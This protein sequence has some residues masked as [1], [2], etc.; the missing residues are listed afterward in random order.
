MADEQIIYLSPEEELTNVRERLEKI[1]SKR[2][3]LVIPAQ[4]QLRSHV[5]WR[6]LHARARELNKEILII[7]SDRQIRSV[8][9]AAGF[10]VADSLESQ[11]S[12]RSRVPSR[13]GRTSLG[14]RTSAR[15]RTPPG[16]AASSP[17]T[18]GLR[19]RQDEQSVPP[20]PP[21]QPIQPFANQPAIEPQIEDLKPRKDDAS[22]ERMSSPASSTFEIE[23]VQD[24]EY[25]PN[26]DYGVSAP[27]PSVRP[28]SPMTPLYEE[29]EPNLWEEDIQRARRI[30]EAAQGDVQGDADTM[31]P[32]IQ[33]EVAP[34][35]KPQIQDLP[36]TPAPRQASDPFS[37]IANEPVAHLPEQHAAL[38]MDEVDEGVADI[39][40]YPTDVINIED[41]GDMGD[42]VRG[43]EPSLHPWTDEVDGDEQDIPGPSRIHGM[44]PRAS[45]SGRMVPE[46]VQ[47]EEMRLPPVYDQPTRTLPQRPSGNLSPAAS[48]GP[49]RSAGKREPQ[50]VA[51]PARMQAKAKPKTTTPLRK[52]K[53]DT[54]VAAIA[55]G[56]GAIA[57]G[58]GR[59]S[60][61]DTMTQGRSKAKGKNKSRAG[62]WIGP[63]LVVLVVLILVLLA[64]FVPSAD[65]TV[66]LLSHK[67]SLP[68]KLTATSTSR[69]DVLHQTLPAQ[70]LT[71][72]NSV[73][74]S[75]RATGS[76]LVG[77][78]LAT[79]NVVF[80]Y[81]GLGQVVIPTGT[82]VA[83]KSGI[84][85]VTQAEVLADGPPTPVQATT[86]GTQGNVLATSI[87]LIP[88]DSLTK[89]QQ[90]NPGVTVNANNLTVTNPN[91]TSGGGAGKAIT[92][93]TNDVDKVRSSLAIQLQ[94]QAKN[95][96]SKNVHTG[97]EAGQPIMVETLVAT[98]AVGNVATD[99]TFTETLKLHM[100]VLIVRF[101]DLQA[102]SSAQLEASLNKQKSNQAL[103][104]Q[105]PV[106]LQQLKNLAPHNGQSVIVSFTA[107]GQVAPRISEDTIRNQVIGKSIENANQ[108]LS[109]NGSVLGMENPQ[110]SV[111]PGFFHWMPFLSQRITV[112]FETRLVQPSSKPK[113]K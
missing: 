32:P 52:K 66:T 49:L 48:A 90:Y 4:T 22:L 5:S 37:Y 25:G 80:I 47:D 9:K 8:V 100:T 62:N 64:L 43:S 2:I 54:S 59:A 55:A 29:E 39:A 60:K 41:Q 95:F 85:F 58:R 18:G 88:T 101:A 91:A 63:V 40:D 73:T 81:N 83:T 13:S 44:R 103:V 106:V 110:I 11:P 53:P 46:P 17:S 38:P 57:A 33:Q 111:S 42:I 14:G 87:I 34:E 112:H 10:K 31:L 45:R 78:A 94:T 69:Q 21:V 27:A 86:A 15:L 77:N 93:T 89:I 6:L 51:L 50:P 79:G 108:A 84:Q 23:D 20:P 74:G 1:P 26:F 70:T 24:E 109:A 56:S 82:T 92:V 3:I 19:S 104:P 98:P 30:R 96:L 67:Y 72:D 76:T 16:R 36:S 68:M 28:I 102:A 71:F 61:Q 99:G 113:K 65:V 107:V 35:D 75:G 105:Q 7:S 97:D 12:S